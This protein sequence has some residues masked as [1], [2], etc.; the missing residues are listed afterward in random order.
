MVNIIAQVRKLKSE[1]QISLKT[2]LQTLTIYSN[3]SDLCAMF[4][5]NAATIK[6]VTQAQNIICTE[7]QDKSISLINNDGTWS[8]FVAAHI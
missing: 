7:I 3:N 5:I 6:G 1:K 4:M 2:S 8:A